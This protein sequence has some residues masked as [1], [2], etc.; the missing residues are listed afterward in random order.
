MPTNRKVTVTASFEGQDY[1]TFGD[2]EYP[3]PFNTTRTVVITDDMP[4]GL[5]KWHPKKRVAQRPRASHH[6]PQTSIEEAR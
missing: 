4:Q 2:N 6:L 3:P 5:L 1:E